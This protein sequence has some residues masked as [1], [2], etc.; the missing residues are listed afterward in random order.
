MAV[1]RQ[2]NSQEV[3][4]SDPT[5]A[6]SAARVMARALAEAAPD[7]Q[8]LHLARAFCHRLVSAWWDKIS[9]GDGRFPLRPLLQPV[10][11]AD[12]PEP[13]A[14]SADSI[15]TAAASVAPETA[16][17]AIGLT[18]TGMLAPT[19]RA[20]YGV[21]YTPPQ[22]TTRL[23]AQATEAGVEWKTARILDPACGGG[24]FLAPVASRILQALPD[25]SPKILVKNIGARLRGYEIDPFAAWL[26]QVTLDAVMLPVCR[27][28]GTRLPVVVTVCDSLKRNPPREKF[29]LV[30]GNPPYGRV[31]LGADERARFKRSLYGHA[32][33]YGLF[34]DLALQHARADGVIAYVTPTSFLAGEY[35]KNLRALIGRDAPPVTIDFLAVRK[36]VFDDVLQETLLA[37]YKRGSTEAAT[38]HEVLPVG[39][40]RLE[41]VDSGTFAVPKDPSEPWI[42]PRTPEQATLVDRLHHMPHR[43]ADWGYEVS[44]GPLVW[45]RFKDQLHRRA[46][47]GRLPLIWAEA[48]TADGRFVFRADKKNHE[49]YFEPKAGDEWLVTSRP[50]VLLQRTTAKEQNRRLIAAALPD[51]F[52]AEHKAVVI[53]NHLNMIRATVAKPK[54]PPATLAA[55]LNSAAADRA[56]R[57]LSGSVAVSAY[58]LEALPLPD[59]AS[60]KGLTKLV[61]ARASRAR[62]EAECDALYAQDERAE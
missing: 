5:G 6:L 21:F 47:K 26:S 25:V 56:F 24:A 59:P 35:F 18:Y 51:A 44:T 19:Y 32:N 52:L 14:A 62:I 1:K 3:S 16:A 11:F 31:K 45:N 13:A 34:T 28:A 36:G 48:V 41:V 12:L 33:L 22:L 30:I 20:D 23:I 43:L 4:D 29:D 49:P 54:V 61:N 37:T 15:G 55:F 50:C 7:A 53:E 60:L 8:R 40:D 10:E 27:K 39:Q 17:Y 38:V 9:E 42:I 57:C 2:R 58:E 46:G